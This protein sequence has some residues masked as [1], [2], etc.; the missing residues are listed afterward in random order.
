M[1]IFEYVE[2]DGNLAGLC[3]FITLLLLIY[4]PSDLLVPVYFLSSFIHSTN[5]NKSV[6]VISPGTSII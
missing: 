4:S 5:V 1:H 3:E 2:D 6:S